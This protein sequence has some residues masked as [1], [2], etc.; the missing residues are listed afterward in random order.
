MYRRHYLVQGTPQAIHMPR[1]ILWRVQVALNR[2]NARKAV[3]FFGGL[4]YVLILRETAALLTRA[5]YPKQEG[6]G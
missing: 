4:R 1:P 5:E 6:Q 2:C 3:G